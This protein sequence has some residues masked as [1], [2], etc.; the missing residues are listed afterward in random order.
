MAQVQNWS[1]TCLNNVRQAIHHE[2]GTMSTSMC[3]AVV[4]SCWA[5]IIMHLISNYFQGF[6]WNGNLSLIVCA[7]N[8]ITGKKKKHTFCFSLIQKWILAFLVMQKKKKKKSFLS[9]NGSKYIQLF[10]AHLLSVLCQGTFWNTDSF[11]SEIHILYHNNMMFLPEI[12]HCIVHIFF[13]ANYF[14]W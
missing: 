12:L 1:S 6:H 2:C 10:T 8:I 3:T 9:C 4:L 7:K 5:V 11:L 13:I 14:W